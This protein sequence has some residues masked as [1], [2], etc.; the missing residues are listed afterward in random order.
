[1]PLRSLLDSL[2]G[3]R[4]PFRRKLR[5]AI[6]GEPPYHGQY[7]QDRIFHQELFGNRRDGVFVDVGAHDGVSLNNTFFLE[8]DLGWRGIC[9]EPIP[10]VFASLA[11]N[12]QASCVQACVAAE[13]GT[14]TFLRVRGYAEMLSGMVDAH[15]PR[16]V[17][18]IRDEVRQFGGSTETIEVRAIP[19]H[20]L[21]REHSIDAVDLL[22]ID[23]EG[24]ELEALSFLEA[25]RV[26]PAVICIENNYLDPR[27]WRRLRQ[28]G[29]RPYARIQQDEIYL[30]RDFVPAPLGARKT[31]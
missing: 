21:L 9:V 1:M 24:A 3:T 29:Y 12:R 6:A 26:R 15:E 14:R 30:F 22:C 10:D 11:R 4:D 7:D 16:H 23:V 27:I 2:F 18:R 31:S 8:R 19:L 28:E 13:A 5:R 25:S 17:E 20:D